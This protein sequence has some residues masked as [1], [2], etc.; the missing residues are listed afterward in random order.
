MLIWQHGTYDRLDFWYGNSDNAYMIPWCINLG[1]G[2]ALL[3]AMD[4]VLA[5]CVTSWSRSDLAT[6]IVWYGLLFCS[7]CICLYLSFSVTSMSIHKMYH[8]INPHS[9]VI[10]H[11]LNGV[12]FF[13]IL[14]YYLC[15]YAHIFHF[16]YINGSTV[17]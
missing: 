9:A 16:Y 7:V 17:L 1:T 2:N 3:K 13:I 14:L 12:F 10:I 11:I 5:S 6:P 4:A 15:F 8:Y